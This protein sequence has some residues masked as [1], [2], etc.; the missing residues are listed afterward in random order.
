MNFFTGLI[1]VLLISGL[2]QD[3]K[4][5]GTNHIK[6]KIFH[7]ICLA[8]ICFMYADAFGVIGSLFSHFDTY[9]QT[10]GQPVGPV[11]GEY[12]LTIFVIRT[13]LS[14]IILFIAFQLIRRREISRWIFIYLLPLLAV[15][16]IF[17]FYRGWISVND[18]KLSPI[19]GILIGTMFIGG[20]AAIL[21]LI[22]N[23]RMMK[24]FFNY[25]ADANIPDDP[26]IIDLPENEQK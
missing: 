14:A 23:S 10:Y 8:L 4:K 17:G 26:S 6:A 21:I 11:N 19:L 15:F 25:Q 24:A 20:I 18:S 22:Y 7:T 16:E 2:I 13:I 5:D 1:L 12:H 9:R 3:Y